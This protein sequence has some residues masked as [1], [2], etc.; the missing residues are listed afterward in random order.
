MRERD[1]LAWRQRTDDQ[2]SG[3]HASSTFD[4]RLLM[5]EASGQAAQRR[6]RARRARQQRQA[7]LRGVAIA[8]VIVAVVGLAWAWVRHG[9]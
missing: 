9:H 8:G 7:L 2:S 4:S 1:D 6:R 3:F 5:K